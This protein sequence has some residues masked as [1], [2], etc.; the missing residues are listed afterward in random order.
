MDPFDSD[1]G[2]YVPPPSTSNPCVSAA[3]S[4]PC[5]PDTDP[6]HR[7]KD[8]YSGD[9]PS[10]EEAEKEVRVS[11]AVLER[12]AQEE[13]TQRK[14]E[15]AAAAKVERTER[16]KNEGSI[17]LPHWY[18]AQAGQ[19]ANIMASWSLLAYALGSLVV[20]FAAWLTVT[21]VKGEE[22]LA[23]FIGGFVAVI[24]LIPILGCCCIGTA[25]HF[26]LIPDYR[27]RLRD[28]PASG[29]VVAAMCVTLLWAWMGFVTEGLTMLFA[30]AGSYEA[31]LA[32]LYCLKLTLPPFPPSRPC[33]H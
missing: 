6:R 5:F 22:Y 13:A 33:D 7:Y 15:E 8:P 18:G 24:L 23:A 25:L 9:M 16:E 20:L 26:L 21:R 19:Q 12:T 4:L 29:S 11:A 27:V 3:S 17:D 2:Y 32:L 10:A 1:A 31:L 14:T 30:I 28:R